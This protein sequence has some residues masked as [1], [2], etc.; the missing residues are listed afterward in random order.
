M[1]NLKNFLIGFGVMLSILSGIAIIF[2]VV[3]FG[4]AFI[5]IKFGVNPDHAMLVTSFLIASI[6]GGITYAVAN[7]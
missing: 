5:I 7:R 3:A 4:K 1:R 6:I 2:Y